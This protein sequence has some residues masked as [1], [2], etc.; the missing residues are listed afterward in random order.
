MVE[1]NGVEAEKAEAMRKYNNRRSFK[2]IVRSFAV[3]LLCYVRFP[4]VKIA[5]DWFYRTGSVIVTNHIFVF[6][7]VNLLIVSI[8]ILSR[9]DER[10]DSSDDD[11]ESDL[12]DQY[13]CSSTVIVTE[14]YYSDEKVKEEDDGVNDLKKDIVPVTIPEVEKVVV[15]E[16]EEVVVVEEEANQGKREVVKKSFRR[17]KS[18]KTK[19][20]VYRPVKEYRRTESAMERMSSEEFRLKVETFIMEKKRSLVLENDVVECRRPGLLGSGGSGDFVGGYGSC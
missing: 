3:A 19:K 1:I 7:V 14:S 12:F 5:G 13:T 17:T 2:N 9:D 4:M 10:S 6:F 15:V 11:T 18:E 8:I 16:E 20:K